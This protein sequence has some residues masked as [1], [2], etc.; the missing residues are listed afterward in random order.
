MIGVARVVRTRPFTSVDSIHSFSRPFALMLHLKG[1][2]RMT[3]DQC[4]S[5]LR[6]CA[7]VVLLFVSVGVADGRLLDDFNDG[8]DE[9]WRRFEW[10]EGEP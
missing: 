2:A 8:N 4:T 6:L 5:V 9:G 1:G 3:T 10:E 7:G